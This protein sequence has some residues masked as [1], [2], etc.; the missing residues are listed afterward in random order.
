MNILTE[1]EIEHI[2]G[3]PKDEQ[4]DYLFLCPHPKFDG[5]WYVDALDPGFLFDFEDMIGPY[6]TVSPAGLERFMNHAA[7]LDYRVY[8]EEDPSNI[9][10]A[11]AHLNDPPSFS[12]NSDLPGTIAGFM[13]FQLQGFNYLRNLANKGGYAVWSTGTGKTALIAGLIKQHVEVE[14]G[15][16]WVLVVVKKS[17]KYDMKS[18]LWELGDIQSTIIT[19]TPE[20][21]DRFYGGIYDQI[22]GG[23]PVVSITNYEK[24]KDDEEYFDLIAQDRRVLVFWDEMPTKLSNRTTQLY[25][26]VRSVLYAPNGKKVSWEKRKPSELRQYGLSATPIENTPVGLLNQIR[27]IDPDVWPSVRGWEKKYV[28]SRNFVSKLPERFKNLDQAGLEIDFMTHQVDKT[29]PDIAKMFPKFIEDAVYIDWGADK[30]YYDK[31]VS[32]A[33]DMA[34]RAKEGEGKKFNALQMIGALQMICDAPSMINTSAQNREVYDELLADAE[35]EGDELGLGG[36]TTGSEAAQA[37]A[38]A[39]DKPLVDTH[40]F[41]LDKLCELLTK[42]HR[43]EKIIMF[44]TFADYIFPII[45]SHFK[46]WGVTWRTFRG[47][48]RQ[49]QMVKDEWRGDPSIQVFLSSDAGSDSID[50]PEASVVIHYDLPWSYAKVIQ[51]QNRA[52]RINSKH[53]SVRAYTLLMAGSVEQRKVEII[54]QKLGFHRSIFKGEIAEDALS[55]RMTGA[56]LY[57]ILTGERED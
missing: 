4:R 31:L 30:V 37:L 47:T 14:S 52:H 16:D 40:S 10:S 17:N 24:F 21:R 36:L 23:E 25:D 41:K 42:K 26:S 3:L 45:E 34:K 49:R 20:R 22:M 35:Y 54:S 33:E 55:A 50:L 53:E 28:A 5:R 11:Y 43:N 46:E 48:D 18:K 57:Y 32:I 13:P 7:D 9:L 1:T 56:D 8:F 15:F 38:R 6:R 39:Y 51:R 44:T 19:G 29:D 12:L 27:L 2:A